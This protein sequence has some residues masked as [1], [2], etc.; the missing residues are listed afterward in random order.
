VPTSE[1]TTGL[2]IR[3]NDPEIKTVEDMA[4]K[5]LGG[6]Q[7]AGSLAVCKTFNEELKKSKGTGFKEIREY[8]TN[9]EVLVDLEN[10]RVDAYCDA[11]AVLGV[12]VKQEPE[13]FQ[14]LGTVGP[15]AYFGWVT[16]LEDK[17]LRQYLNERITNLKKD[18]TIDSLQK[19]WFGLV[20]DNPTSNYEPT[21]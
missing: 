18:G 12:R 6:Q 17:E 2:L 10:K 8:V 5:I 1:A 11:L 7:G 21:Q 9:P 14:V 3:K 20:M 4:G 13:K 15:K 19:K 16:R